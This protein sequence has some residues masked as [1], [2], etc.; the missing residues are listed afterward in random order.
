[1]DPKSL[2]QLLKGDVSVSDL[3]EW[4]FPFD[5]E[6]L[7]LDGKKSKSKKPVHKRKQYNWDKATWVNWDD[8][9]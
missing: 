6:V 8:E 2:K 3:D 4:D 1:M 5:E 7:A 9:E